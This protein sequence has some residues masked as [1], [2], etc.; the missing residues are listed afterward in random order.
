MHP[1]ESEQVPG[2]DRLR[3]SVEGEGEGILFD[4]KQRDEGVE[5][6]ERT[7][8]GMTECHVTYL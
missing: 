1:A 7:Q 8:G 2:E 6:W 4:G 3:E 5:P